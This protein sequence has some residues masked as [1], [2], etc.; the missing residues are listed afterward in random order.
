MFKEIREAIA[1]HKETAGV[2]NILEMNSTTLEKLIEES[3][4]NPNEGHKTTLTTYSF[5]CVDIIVRDEIPD[6]Q[7]IVKYESKKE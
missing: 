7:F 3:P 2:P 5:D 6:D 1:L 4:H